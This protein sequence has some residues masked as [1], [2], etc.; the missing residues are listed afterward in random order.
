MGWHLAAMKS[1]TSPVPDFIEMTGKRVSFFL[2]AM[3]FQLGLGLAQVNL[4]VECLSL[5]LWRGTL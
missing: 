5:G 1:T 2:I 3:C 4:R